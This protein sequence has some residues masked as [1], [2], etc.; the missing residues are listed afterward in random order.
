[1]MP[2][3][4]GQRPHEE[5]AVRFDSING[6]DK[7]RTHLINKEWARRFLAGGWQGATKEH[8]LKAL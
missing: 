2:P 5:Q 4:E 8:S 3:R 1:M 6:K 7:T